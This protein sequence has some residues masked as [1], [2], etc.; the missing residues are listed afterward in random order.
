MISKFCKSINCPRLVVDEFLS[1]T[2]PYHLC[3]AQEN[4]N[5]HLGNWTEPVRCISKE[6]CA[7]LRKIMMNE[8]PRRRDEQGLQFAKF[9][10]YKYV[11]AL[12]NGKIV[13]WGMKKETMKNHGKNP[14]A[15]IYTVL[16]YIKA[17]E[18]EK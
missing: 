3:N 5:D 14:K 16:Q 8:G 11:E 9:S 12:P 10:H 13:G 1:S 2:R 7:E 6:R 17:T 4:P 18:E 15:T